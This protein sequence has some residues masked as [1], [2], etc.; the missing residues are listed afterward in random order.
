M[1]L[2]EEKY[3]F[4]LENHIILT[5]KQY[6]LFPDEV[7][8]CGYRGSVVHNMYIPANKPC[9]IDDID[10]VSIY[11]ATP[12]YYLGL[13]NKEYAKVHEKFVGVYD[14]VSYEIRHFFNLLTK[15]NPS[16][17]SL[18]WIPPEF[19]FKKSKVGE[20]IIENRD[21][22]TSKK[23]YNT[24]TGY[25][26]DQLKRTTKFQTKGYMGEKRK[27]LVERF[28]FDTK[29]AAHCIRLL[30]MG[31]EFLKT[32]QLN[33][34]REFPDKL[35][36]IRNGELSLEEIK[37]LAETLAKVAESEYNKSKLPDEPHTLKIERLLSE[38]LHTYLKDWKP[39][40]QTGW[41]K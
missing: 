33:V 20:Y 25:A 38:I 12:Y 10:L 34:F 15:S 40:W 2:S 21:I 26:F 18:L 16:S 35:L 11:F 7:I 23:I 1:K 30:E 14:T 27:L 5:D 39:S 22:F 19:Y 29:N 31:I 8:L 41:R 4:L 13:G 17:L 6:T 37:Q 9:G 36:S 28:G 24:F 3:K 32:G